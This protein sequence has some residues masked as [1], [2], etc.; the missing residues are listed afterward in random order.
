[1]FETSIA[2]SLPKPSWLAERTNFG[3]PGVSTALSWKR[4]RLTRPA[5]PQG[6]GGRRH[7][8]RHRRRAITP[9]FRPR[10]SRIRRRDRLRAQGRNGDPRRSLQGD[11]AAGDWSAALKRGV[12]ETEAPPRARHTQKKLKFTL[13]GPRRSSTRS[14]T[15]TTAI[16]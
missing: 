3:P 13:P 8:H 14:P 5:R 10:I 6:A 4:P 1:M 9:A 2:G 15:A 16:A 7:R 12:H 11:G